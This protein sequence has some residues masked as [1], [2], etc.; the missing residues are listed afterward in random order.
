MGWLN[1]MGTGQHLAQQPR[2]AASE[3]QCRNFGRHRRQHRNFTR[4]SLV[5]QR[6]DSFNVWVRHAPSLS[7]TVKQ[8]IGQGDDGHSLVMCHEGGNGR[9]CHRLGLSAR[10]KIQCVNETIFSS[11]TDGL[12][13]LEVAYRL[14]N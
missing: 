14:V 9:A 10:R 3:I 4:N 8:G 2:P 11:A 6:T 13:S 12:E 7:H 5:Q 1:R